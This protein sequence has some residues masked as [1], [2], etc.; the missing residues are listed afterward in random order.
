MV[1]S[2]ERLKERRDLECLSVPPEGF[3]FV[4][5]RFGACDD[6]FGGRAEAVQGAV[7]DGREDERRSAMADRVLFLR[8]RRVR[9]WRSCIQVEG[10]AGSKGSREEE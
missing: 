2:R 6:R 4:G 1:A 8:M 5:E 9:R 3:F 10:G 7:K